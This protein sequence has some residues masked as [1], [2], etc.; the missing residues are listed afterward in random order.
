MKKIIVC[1]LF[2][3]LI[4]YANVSSAFWI[5]SPKSNEWKNPQMSPLASPQAQLEKAMELYNEEKYNQALDEFRKLVIHFPDSKK[6]PEAQ[7]YI[8]KCFQALEKP[9]HA[10]K[11]YQKV[12]DSYPYSERILEIV[13]IE[14]EI[15]E[16]YLNRQRNEWL[17]ISFDDLFAHPSIEILKQVIDN[18]PY[19]E[20]AQ[21]AHYKLG[22]LLKKL[23][24]Y[25]QAISYFNDLIEKY[26]E[27]E[28]VEPARYQLALTSADASLESEYDQELTE[29]AQDQFE[30]FLTKHPDA[31]L[32]GEVQEE[33]K[34]LKSKEAKKYFDIA[35]FYNKQNDS[36]SAG[37]YYNYVINNYPNSSW[38]KKAE[39]KLKKLKEK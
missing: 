21:K 12:V 14:Y 3:L 17:G 18:A 33:L 1:G 2:A 25:K 23:G 6:A 32:S 37:L 8:R 15:G 24:R 5:W 36:E 38:S 9:Y 29:E 16:Y 30:Q 4:F 28:W 11:A 20:V 27:S 31:E 7:F 22:L 10:F 34:V 26:P 13:K 19:S 39:E 35:E